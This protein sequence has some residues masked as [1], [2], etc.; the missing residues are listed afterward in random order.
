MT[1][2]GFTLL[3]L[4]VV[5]AIIGI[6]SSIGV[7]A[8][9]GYTESAAQKAAENSLQAMTIA[10]QEYKSNQGQY[11]STGGTSGTCTPTA[12]TTTAIIGSSTVTST[13][14]LFGGTD[15]LTGQRYYFCSTGDS[16]SYT[17]TAKH[18]S[19]TCQITLTNFNVWT[20][21]GCDG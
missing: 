12:A 10:Q 20:R 2:R 6:L 5:I 9:N 8:Y 7:V 18:S 13:P 4:L 19:K 15:N 17:L 14:G 16:S 21:T 3:E 1:I 11:F